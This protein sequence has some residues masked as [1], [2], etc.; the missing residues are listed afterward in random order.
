MIQKP[1]YE[2]LEKKIQKLEQSDKKARENE[3]RYKL[4]FQTS[5]DAI[6]IS[7][8]SDGMFIN[9]NHGFTKIMGY[10][11]DDDIGKTSLSLNMWAN[12]E[13]RNRLINSLAK[14]GYVDNM[15][16]RFICKGGRIVVGL[17]SAHLMQI[18][19]EDFI[20]SIIRN[21]TQFKNAQEALQKSEQQLSTHLLNTPIGAISWDLNFKTIEW[22][23]A[24]E[25]IFGYTKEEA[26]GKHIADLILTEDSKEI[27]EDIFQD[28]LSE[29]G[30]THS[31][32]E[33]ITKKGRRIICDWYNTVLQDA[34]GKNIGMASLVN[35][36]SARKQTE[37]AL[38]ESEEGLKTILS[39]TPDPIAIYNNQGGTEY[40]NP[41]FIKLFGW[42]LDEL[43]GKRIPFVPDDQKKITS[44]KVKELLSS[45]KKVQFE[46][47][48][49]TKKGR[50]IDVIISSSCIKDINGKISK[51]VVILK[52]ITE[53]K[54]IRNELRLL[55]IKLEHKATHDSLTGAP[56]RGA[57]LDRLRNE[58][59]RAKRGNLKL[60]IGICDIDHFKHVNDKYGH[61]AGDDVLFNFVKIIQKT[62]RPYD[63]VGRYGGEEFLLVIPDLPDSIGMVEEKIYERVRAITADQKMVTRA[64]KI[65]I[66]ISIGITSRRGDETADAMIARAD[67]AL[68]R[69]KENGRN[70]LAFA[71]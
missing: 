24:A 1:T 43:E 8:A 36:I 71:D 61:Q 50:S 3:E 25:N 5:P 60:S 48:R 56:N 12:P 68:Y 63:M 9:V 40:L 20:L 23:P 33:N 35:D 39:A 59:L 22:N 18:N 13:D 27:V 11:Q 2:E 53:Q 42:S 44:E 41:A 49:L 54:Q 69:A 38:K 7:R 32:N 66:T 70:Q 19:G 21:I 47:K 65:S 55:N 51:L 4:A 6:N 28:I 30:G 15:E 62:L 58:L 16:A 52:D 37:E 29:K 45:G 10:K 67:A 57:I 26:L 46:S 14:T 64:G 34:D 31:I 17:L